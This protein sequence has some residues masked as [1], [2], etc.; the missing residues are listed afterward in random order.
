MPHYVIGWRHNTYSNAPRLNGVACSP[1]RNSITTGSTVTPSPYRVF[2]NYIF[3]QDSWTECRK[4]QSSQICNE[5]YIKIA[6]KS[7]LNSVYTQYV[8]DHTGSHA[9]QIFLFMQVFFPWLV[10]PRNWATLAESISFQT[11]NDKNCANISPRYG[12]VQMI[13][14]TGTQ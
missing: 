9:W 4:L 1:N 2:S 7:F 11:F 12:F 6:K 13:M 8:C 10:V 5:K 14:C 3:H